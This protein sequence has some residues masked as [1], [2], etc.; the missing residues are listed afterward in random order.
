MLPAIL[1][2]L[3]DWLIVSG[4]I[5]RQAEAVNR[6]F[7]WLTDFSQGVFQPALRLVVVVT[8]AVICAAVRAA[9]PSK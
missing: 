1:G 2:F 4:R 6:R 5:D 7:Q 9:A 8:L 3:V